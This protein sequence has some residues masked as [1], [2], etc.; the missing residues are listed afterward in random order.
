MEY[1][2]LFILELYEENPV[3]NL[4]HTETQ[5]G[6]SLV[7]STFCR[8]V[9][10][11]SVRKR[12]NYFIESSDIMSIGRADLILLPNGRF[13]QRLQKLF[14]AFCGRHA[15]REVCSVYQW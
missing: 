12:E 3:M 5:N 11:S 15:F 6:T 8:L 14:P 9:A 2:N 10:K 13:R 1:R 4:I 7:C